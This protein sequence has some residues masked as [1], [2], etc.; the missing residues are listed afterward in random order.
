MISDQPVMKTD[1]RFLSVIIVG[2]DDGKG[3]MDHIFGGDNRLTGAPG[4]YA[5]RR[6]GEILRKIVQLL[7]RV[8]HLNLL[9]HAISDDVSEI[10]LQILPNNEHDAVK[11]RLDGIVNRV[12]HDDLPA[13]SHR[14]QLF[15]SLAESASDSRCHNGQCCFFHTSLLHDYDRVPKNLLPPCMMTRRRTA[16]QSLPRIP[17]RHSRAAFAHMPFSGPPRQR[18]LRTLPLRSPPA[19]PTDPPPSTRRSAHPDPRS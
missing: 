4:F 12:I 8:G 1:K 7:E 9:F 19:L 17:V 16:P 2:I 5:V 11:A 3:L 13:G 14:L 18:C 6:S 10:L 15:D